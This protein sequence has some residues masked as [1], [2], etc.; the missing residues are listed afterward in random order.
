MKKRRIKFLAESGKK[1][2]A[3][4]YGMYLLEKSG[5]SN[6]P[7][8]LFYLKLSA[9]QGYQPAIDYLETYY[10]DDDSFSQGNS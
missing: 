7:Q 9:E 4:K 6:D 3:Y 5:D 10:F 1:E 2:E 8:G